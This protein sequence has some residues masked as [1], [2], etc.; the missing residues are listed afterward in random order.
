M[1]AGYKSNQIKLNH[2]NK[3]LSVT[4]SSVNGTKYWPFQN[5][6]GDLWWEGSSSPKYYR[7]EVEFTVTH[8]EHGS[9]LTRDDFKYN[10]MDVVVG[11]WIAGATDGKCV[12]IIE[13]KNK[14]R[15]SV[16]CVV[17][18]WLRYNTFKATTGNGI[19]NTGS[20]I[21]FT[22]NENGFPMLDPLPTSVT[23]NFYPV[24]ASRFQ[25]LNPQINFVLEKESH[26]FVKGDVISVTADDGFTKANAA[27]ADRMVGVVTESGP[28][29][30]YF[31]ILP[32]NRIIDFDPTIPGKQG[33][34]IYVTD[35]GKL[36][37]VAGTG[38]KI[39]FLNIRAATPTEIVGTQGNP[40]VG[41]GNT[42]VINN[43]SVTFNGSGNSAGVFE[44]QQAINAVSANTDVV[45]DVLP[46]ENT[47]ISSPDGTAYGLVG[48]Y[49]PF[50]AYFNTGSGNTLVT[51]TSAGSQ[52]DGVSTPQDLAVDLQSA[53]IA[54]L[55]VTATATTLTISELNGNAITITNN[56][57][58]SGGNP[59]VG[60][61]NI[62]GLPAVTTA[63]D[64]DKLRLTRNNGGEILIFED[65][66][67]FQTATGIFSGH[68]GSIP[69]AMN[70]EQGVRT[71]GTVVVANIGARDALVPA[72]GDQAYVI[73][74]GDGEWGL[75]LY[76]GSEWVQTS[77]ADSAT[78][79]AK[80]L[81]ATI[82]MPADGFGNSVTA[83]LGN[84]SPGRKITTVSVDVVNALTDATSTPTLIVGTQADRDLIMDE[85]ST[86][87]TDQTTFVAFP[88][89][90]YPS[91][92]TQ[93]MVVQAQL[94]HFEAV[95]GNVIVR[96]T[97]V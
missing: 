26:G 33:E 63:S 71:G 17:E 32:N 22:L 64:S 92:Q 69:L 30:N 70:I 61:S 27:T 52:Y 86:D 53:N 68:T 90:V 9:H 75:Y 37:N 25:Y 39:A 49:A 77:N 23:A 15:N 42:I 43:H 4:V 3:V 41:N 76:T 35:N 8:Q 50:S 11:D 46:V 56:A 89:Y 83:E 85:T 84:I 19:F 66:D 72:A 51:F 54:N 47:I 74:K 62:S 96:V 28:G 48:G 24:V 87:L 21:I 13:I 95:S 58:E 97:Y 59:F 73:N 88:E 45:A 29:P 79:D 14:T 67:V 5:G 82:A 38:G 91:D 20:A 65:S 55:N 16:T 10:G 12:K 7:W 36:S 93:D 60:S 34:Y 80:T 44:M 18:D 78:T 1:S 31:M 2:P 81:T 57:D 94:N 40:T 6:S